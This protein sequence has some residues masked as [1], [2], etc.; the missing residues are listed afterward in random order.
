VEL[1]VEIVSARAV[2]EL[3]A[4]TLLANETVSDQSPSSLAPAF[5]ERLGSVELRP[6]QIS[7]V[8][9]IGVALD[10]FGGALLADEVGM[11]KTFVALAVATRFRRSIVIGPAVLRDMW[12]HQE[13]LAGME[14]PFLSFESLSR[15]RHADGPFDLVVV[16]EA[17]HVR[18]PTTRRYLELSRMAMRARV[19]MLSAT[20]VHNRRSD[21]TALLAI[22]LGSQAESLSSTEIAR[23]VVRRGVESAGLSASIPCTGEL[24]WKELRDDARVPAAL[25]SLPPPLPARG[26]GVGGV[27][28]ARSLLRQWCSSDATLE[29]ALRRRLAR[30][31]AL[32][33]ALESGHYPSQKELSAWTIADDSVQLAFPSLVAT[34]R[35]DAAE[36]LGTINE[37]QKALREVLRSLDPEHPRDTGRAAFLKEIRRAHPGIPVVAFSQYAETVNALFRELRGERGIAVLTAKGA[38]VAGGSITRR[39]ALSR[40]APR[41]SGAP[42]PRD[43]ERIDFL[44]ATDLLSEGVNL[45]DAGVVVHMDLPWTAARLEQRLGRV[46]RMGSAHGRVYAYGIRPPAAA[47]ILIRLEATITAKMREAEATVGGFHSILPSPPGDEL[48]AAASANSRVAPRAPIAAAERIR[49]ILR[50]WYTQNALAAELRLPLA[51]EGTRVAAVG[52]RQSGFLAMCAQGARLALVASD[53]RRVTNEPLEVLDLLLHAD[54]RD[55]PPQLEA[56]TGALNLLQSHLRTEHTVALT[57]PQ[58]AVAA[59]ARRAALRRVS[60]IVQNGRPHARSR[61]LELA[62]VARD[63]I[64]GRLGVAAEA[65]LMRMVKAD[66]PDEEWLRAIGDQVA[67]AVE[68][69]HGPGLRHGRASA[70]RVMAILLLEHSQSPQ[71]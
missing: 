60:A 31:I 50:R 4:R 5:P 25:L 28:V 68:A 8:R 69:K 24:V 22:F 20:P 46:V 55:V 34:P 53:G 45:Q 14:I 10:E 42:P 12:S 26:G 2:R 44:L 18:N 19:L 16:D 71:S 35:D 51:S 61:L 48:V 11:G 23:C 65:E 49:F 30:S 47:D 27:L 13:R 63:A 3:I 38:R 66:L 70:D 40:F 37:H 39:E 62:I 64:L 41:A 59:Q 56:V 1:P 7:A 15:G 54:G 33:S 17:H 29:S 21:L 36:L 43:V 52:S 32:I 9:R 67:G 57:A 6:H 58:S